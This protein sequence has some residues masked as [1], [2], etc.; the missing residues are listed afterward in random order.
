MK[1]MIGCNYW[2]SK[3]GTDMWRKWDAESVRNDLKILSENG[4]EVMR[5]FPNWREFQPIMSVKEW[6]GRRAE[7]L[8]ADETRIDN[9]FGID[10]N[11]MEHF[12]LFCDYAKEFNI[13][14]VV[15]VVTGWM[16]GRLFVPPALEGKNLIKD[17]EALMWETK[18]VRGFIRYFKN[19][20]EIIAWDLG[21]EC[22]CMGM[23]EDRSDAYTWTALISK[24]I[25]CE[26]K[27]RPVM[28]G[29]HSLT[30]GEEWPGNNNWTIQ[31]QGELTDILTPHPYPSP[32]VGGDRE[33]CNTMRPTLIP[34]AQV[35]YYR[36]IGI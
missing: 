16:S 8:F 11:Q 29:M 26:D 20:E 2:G 6:G 21:N 28:S 17:S 9:E 24:S 7:Y 33:H 32:T 3:H 31:D 35:N 27:T 10:Y 19:R 4:V 36:G 15:S 1:Y 13:K 25:Y 34:L 14:L 5:V 22:N 12:S 23:I 30:H 18:F